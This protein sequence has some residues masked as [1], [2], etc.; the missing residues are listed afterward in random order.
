MNVSESACGWSYICFYPS[1]KFGEK[2]VGAM[3]NLAA[4]A[5]WKF[6]LIALPLFLMVQGAM[7]AVVVIGNSNISVDALTSAQVSEIFLGKTTSLA[8]GTKITVIEHQDGESIKDEFYEKVVGKSASQLKAYWA[9]IIF[10]GEGMPPKAY[11]GDKSVRDHVSMTPGAVG[12]VS[13]ESV[14][15]SVKVLFEGK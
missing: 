11:S 8:D 4:R 14:D 10:T 3:G 9:K 7:A 13:A 2:G 15:K 12:Y 6:G 5:K 1:P